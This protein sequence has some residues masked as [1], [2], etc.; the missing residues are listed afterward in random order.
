MTKAHRGLPFPLSMQPATFSF[1]VGIWYVFVSYDLG[2]VLLLTFWCCYFITCWTHISFF[3]FGSHASLSCTFCQGLGISGSLSDSF[4]LM[5]I[6][7][8]R[9]VF[10]SWRFWP[11]VE[12][13]ISLSDPYFTEYL[14]MC[15][16]LPVSYLTLLGL[17]ELYSC[18]FSAPQFC[19]DNAAPEIPNCGLGGK[20][21]VVFESLHSCVIT[22]VSQ[23]AVHN[24]HRNHIQE[25]LL[26]YSVWRNFVSCQ[27]FVLEWTSLK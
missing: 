21:T 4:V 1:I 3:Q 16:H 22:G 27:T 9:T 15:A 13:Y 26:L 5:S 10:P 7:I 23:Q 12:L 24:F 8:F 6:I 14:D 25:A 17:M 19:P 2:V 20:I 11:L 18:R